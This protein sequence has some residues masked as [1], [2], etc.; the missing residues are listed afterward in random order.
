[1]TDPGR[2]PAGVGRLRAWVREHL[3]VLLFAALLLVLL[4]M[5][6]LWAPDE[7]D[8][9]QCVR[10]MRERGTWLLPYLNGQPYDEKPILFFWL[11]KACA[12]AGE[13]LTGGRGF[14]HHTAAWA[15]R[16]PSVLAAI[17]FAAGFHRW[18]KRFLGDAA[19]ERAALILFTAPLWVWQS[20][21][22]QIDLLF[23]ALLA[24]S[25]LSWLAGYL[26]LTGAAPAHRPGEDATWLRGAY[27]TLGLA[28]LAKGPLGLVLSLALALAFLAWQ[29]DWRVLGRLRLPA[30]VLILAAVVVPW[31]FAAWLKGG[32]G[33]FH[34]LV[35]HQ[36]LER[37]VQAWDHAQPWWKYG[38]YLLGD[39][40]PWI[41]LLPALLAA[42]WRA[43]RGAGPGRR[44]F[45]LAILVPLALLSWAESK[46]GKYLLMAHPFLAL[47]L[48]ESPAW[49]SGD[50]APRARRWA[51]LLLAGALALPGLVLAGVAL[52]PL[53]DA[54]L[55]AETRPFAG[56]MV[57]GA[58]LFLGGSLAVL[59]A[60]LGGRL[61]FRACALTLGAV[62]LVGGGWA[63]ARLDRLKSYRRWTEAVAPLIAGRQVYF[64]QTLRSG[65]MVYTDT[66]MPE[67]RTVAEL[68]D[69]LGPGDRLVSQRR[70]WEQDLG[71]MTPELRARFEIELNVPV[72]ASE[73]LLLKRAPPPLRPP[74]AP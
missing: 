44:F 61:P 28:T 42:G 24:W 35:V 46:Q 33:Y 18:A 16:L 69:R 67:L 52:L 73:L 32:S 60:T 26:L 50:A 15:L 21:A 49:A 20:Q 10:E 4:P 53:P 38:Q 71:G 31:Y 8:Y 74:E 17:L 1:M 68:Q 66:L 72:G 57:L 51:G 41:A 48:A 13:W 39:L 12:V 63:F 34:G 59:R 55:L 36:N 65:A 30:G 23:S 19:G 40:W 2:A 64:W 9:A 58:L 56:V 6:D 11:M 54:R 25:W 27:L 37:A 29:R 45:L 7:P 14:T 5:R 22:I 47:V 43:G 62:Y 70:E 3:G